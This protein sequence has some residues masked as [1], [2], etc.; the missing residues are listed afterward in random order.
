MRTLRVRLE[1][2][3]ASSTHLFYDLILRDADAQATV[4]LDLFA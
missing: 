4:Q 1:Y 3:A 2:L